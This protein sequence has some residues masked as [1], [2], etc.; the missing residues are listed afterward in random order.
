[1]KYIIERIDQVKKTFDNTI[2]KNN[3]YKTI[4]K[5]TVGETNSIDDAVKKIE[6]FDETCE[7]KN[8]VGKERMYLIKETKLISTIMLYE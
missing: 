8:K 4:E 7:I 5:T 3:D 2:R 1:M 6:K